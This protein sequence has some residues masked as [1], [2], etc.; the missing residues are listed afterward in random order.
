MKKLILTIAILGSL[1][2]CSPPPVL[3]AACGVWKTISYSASDDTEVTKTQIKGNNAA[4]DSY[5]GKK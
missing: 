1:S 3:D 5:C 2:A 4:H